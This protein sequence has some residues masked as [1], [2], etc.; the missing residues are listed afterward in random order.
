MLIRSDL[1]AYK[2]SE[3]VFMVLLNVRMPTF[4]GILT[5]MSM[6]NV[7]LSWIEA[8]PPCLLKQNQSSGN[9]Y[10]IS[11]KLIM[12]VSDCTYQGLLFRDGERF[13]D[14]TNTC[15]SC[16]CQGGDVRCE[17]TDCP[18]VGLALLLYTETLNR[19]FGKL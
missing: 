14:P 11:W 10:N 6:I 7:M 16:L 5:V 1:I 18:A 4:V 8:S 2:L 19:Y 13:D 12:C 15:Q 17:N 9:Q 3:V